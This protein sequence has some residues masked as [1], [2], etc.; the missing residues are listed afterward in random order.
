MSSAACPR[1]R[2]EVEAAF[3]GIALPRPPAGMHDVGDGD[4][5]AIGREFLWNLMQHAGLQPGHRVL[6]IGCGVG[7]LAIP[8]TAFLDPGKGRYIGFDVA[9]EA[10]GWCARE[11]AGRHAN[12]AFRP[13]DL[14]HALYNPDGALDPL[15]F[16]FPVAEASVD[17]AAAISVFTH[18]PPDVMA[19]YLRQARRSLA[20]G[21]QFFCTAFLLDEAVR[22]RLRAGACRI[23]FRADDPAFW[24]EGHEE[25]P[26][27]AIAVDLDWFLAAAARAGLELAAPVV[28]GHWPDDSGGEGFQDICVLKPTRLDPPGEGG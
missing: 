14:R 9:A 28:R 17:L 15:S 13:A 25:Y 21:G 1:T 16:V 26:G 22:R 10:I 23:P 4:F 2:Q 27:A 6:D 24:Q 19:H 20:P 12:F 18:L 7:R 5:D 8:L 3:G 11:I